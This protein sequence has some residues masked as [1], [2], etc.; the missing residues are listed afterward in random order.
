[1][2]GLPER[3]GVVLRDGTRRPLGVDPVVD[4]R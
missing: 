3:S 1:V 4:L 2:L